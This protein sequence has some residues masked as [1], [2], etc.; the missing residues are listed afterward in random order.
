MKKRPSFK[1]RPSIDE[2]TQSTGMGSLDFNIEMARRHGW[3]LD[4]MNRF[5]ERATK[6]YKSYTVR[7]RR[8]NPHLY[9]SYRTGN[10]VT[11]VFIGEVP[12]E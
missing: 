5:W 9:R 2:E 7:V 3:T 1:Q 12:P 4:E 6:L 8:R 11:W 10:T